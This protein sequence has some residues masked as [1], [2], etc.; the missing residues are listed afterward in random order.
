M[1]G[2]HV[3]VVD[4]D[5]RL[6]DLLG[7]YLTE[8]GYL[9]VTAADAAEARARMAGLAFDL[10]VLDVMM[11]GE[12]GMS[13]TRSLRA[14]GDRVPILLLTA[15][16]EVDDRIR[17]LEAGAD[18]YLSKPFEPRELLLRVGSILRRAPR[19]D[20]EPAP[21][22]LRLGPFT[23]DIARAEL[24]RG[25]QPV[26]LTQAERD[27]LAVLAETAGQGVSRDELA[28]RTGSAANPRA[29]DVQVTRLRKKIEDDPRLP[30]YLQ[31]VRGTGYMLRPD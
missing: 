7:K 9:V 31:T 29:V 28:A 26:H 6:R 1:E 16:G 19:D 24:R 17:G 20:A 3:L 8:N 27:L 5:R 18:D 13:L 4:D 11:P 14:G 15:R 21:T 30:R 25:D 22:T 23:W 2:G 10:I 12:D